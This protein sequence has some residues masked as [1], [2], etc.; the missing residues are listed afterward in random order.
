[1]DGGGRFSKP[2]PPISRW[3][4]TT[5]KIAYLATFQPKQPTGHTSRVIRFFRLQSKK[6]S[7]HVAGAARSSGR[8][9]NAKEKISYS[10]TCGHCR[11]QR[12]PC[13]V[14]RQAG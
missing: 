7:I 13:S 3:L 9:R 1:M 2:I 6:G 4:P 14:P 11:H 12:G 10:N 8:L 5:K